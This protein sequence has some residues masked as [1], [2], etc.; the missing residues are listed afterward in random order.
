MLIKYARDWKI[1]NTIDR[2]VYSKSGVSKWTLLLDN[3][4]FLASLIECRILQMVRVIKGSPDRYINYKA[5]HGVSHPRGL[6]SS[7]IFSLGGKDVCLEIE[8][9]GWVCF[10]FRGIQRS[11]VM[12]NERKVRDLSCYM[13]PA[14]EFNSGEWLVSCEDPVFSDGKWLNV[15]GAEI[16]ALAI[17]MTQEGDG[18]AVLRVDLDEDKRFYLYF[19]RHEFFQFNLCYKDLPESVLYHPVDSWEMV[20]PSV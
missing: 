16:R 15:I 14:M 17:G 18:Q 8:R 9:V 19:G 5:L 1:S 10:Y 2:I 11:I 13:D 12:S 4:E 6:K 7:E 3:K 20:V